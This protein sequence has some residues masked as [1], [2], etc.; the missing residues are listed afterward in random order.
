MVNSEEE[1]EEEEEEKENVL[2]FKVFSDDEE[3]LFG[4]EVDNVEEFL[5]ND[6]SGL[7]LD[8]EDDK[9]K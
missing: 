4:N 7:E 1:K 2:N 6:N 3:F 5:L 8:D 9:V